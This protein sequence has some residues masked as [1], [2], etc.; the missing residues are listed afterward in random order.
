LSDWNTNVV[1]E[2]RKNEGRV[3]GMFE[4]APLLLLHTTGNKSGH[5]RVNPLMYLPDGDRWVIFASKGGHAAHPHWLHN[6]E[7]DPLA[8]VEVGT[9]TV[10]V[11]ATILREGPERNDLYARQVASYPQFGEYEKKTAGHRTIPVIVLERAG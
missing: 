2:F 1:E 8:T 9:A 10:P 7:A 4:G 5:D 6:L 11:Q 3:G